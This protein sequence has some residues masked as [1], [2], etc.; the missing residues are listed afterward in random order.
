MSSTTQLT[1]TLLALDFFPPFLATHERSQPG[2]PGYPSAKENTEAIEH[3]RPALT[4]VTSSD[5]PVTGHTVISDIRDKT[6]LIG[7]S[8]TGFEP[9]C[10]KK[11]KTS[12]C[13][14]ARL[15]PKHRSQQ[16]PGHPLQVT[17]ATLGTEMSPGVC[18]TASYVTADNLPSCNRSDTK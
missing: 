8:Q 2:G 7:S 6:K 11:V 4:M 10:H 16:G 5:S 3:Q 1:K 14:T 9:S 15:T 12:T 13:L 18:R 17:A